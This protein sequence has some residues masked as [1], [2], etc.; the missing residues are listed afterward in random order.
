[1]SFALLTWRKLWIADECREETIRKAE[2]K[3][4]HNKRQFLRGAFKTHVRW[5]YGSF[6]VAKAFLKY[7]GA[8]LT[9]IVQALKEYKT[10]AR[11]IQRKADSEPKRREEYRPHAWSAMP[12]ENR[13][14]PVDRA[15][16]LRN[17]YMN[18]F[19][20][21]QNRRVFAFP[22]EET[23]CRFYSGDLLRDANT[24]TREAGYG[25]IRDEAGRITDML[26]PAA[27]EDTVESD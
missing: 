3:N 23:M 2:T 4:N 5:Q 12:L 1:M 15:R 13:D 9:K 27:F 25:A 22:T 20:Y 11:Y 19:R 6:N 10:S 17:E 18:A 24:A 16:L 7:P 26:Q 8:D 21:A 14:D